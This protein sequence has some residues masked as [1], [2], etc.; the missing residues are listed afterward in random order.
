MKSGTWAHLLCSSSVTAKRNDNVLKP[1]VYPL[2]Q[3]IRGVSTLQPTAQFVPIRLQCAAL[4]NDIAVAA[5][6]YIP[7][8]PVLLAVLTASPFRGDKIRQKGK[9]GGKMLK[10][11]DM[12][13]TL[14]L[15]KSGLETHVVKDQVVNRTL[16]L[17]TDL[18]EIHKFSIAFPEFL[19]PISVQLRQ[20][21]KTCKN[22]LWRQAT[23]HLLKSAEKWAEDVRKRRCDVNFGPSDVDAVAA[24]MRNEKTESRRVRILNP[25]LGREL[26]KGHVTSSSNSRKRTKRSENDEKKQEKKTKKQKKSNK[27]EQKIQSHKEL[28]KANVDAPDEMGDLDDWTDEDDS[29]DDEE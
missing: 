22:S 12:N 25:L 27:K 11:P 28:E 7:T 19:F 9:D 20:F 10:P 5:D 23:K 2:I 8:A 6:V 4:L 24:F 16:Q 1:L 18:L 13:V 17:L 29:E 14:R 21:L 26:R 15:Q 3:I